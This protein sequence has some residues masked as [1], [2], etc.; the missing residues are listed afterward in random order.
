MSLLY[1][2]HVTVVKTAQSRTLQSAGMGLFTAQL[3]PLFDSHPLGVQ[4]NSRN[5]SDA[6]VER[7]WG[8][9]D[10]LTAKK[11]EHALGRMV[12]VWGEKIQLFNGV[13]HAG[14]ACSRKALQFGACKSAWPCVTIDRRTQVQRRQTRKA[15]VMIS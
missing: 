9:A 6:R 7:E 14:D 5:F 11:A 4:W 8:G 2:R 12:N 15:L 3:R 13:L 1:S 10:F